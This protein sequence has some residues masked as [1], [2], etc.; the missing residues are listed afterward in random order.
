MLELTGGTGVTVKTNQAPVVSGRAE[1]VAVTVALAYVSLVW[2]GRVEVRTDS[3]PVLARFS[4]IDQVNS[5]SRERVAN[6]DVYRAV[7][8]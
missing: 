5:R 2:R 6:R 1:C 8:P 4:D 3:D 7:K